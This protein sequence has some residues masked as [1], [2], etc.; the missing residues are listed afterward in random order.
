MP[1]N[2][3]G[4]R[5]NARSQTG[6]FLWAELRQSSGAERRK[7]VAH[8]VS[9]GFPSP[10]V[11]QPWRGGRILG[12][13]CECRAPLSPL[14][15]SARLNARPTAYAVGYSLPVLRTFEEDANTHTRPAPIR[16]IFIG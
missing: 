10:W 8:S 3:K 2:L 16:N 15:G 11:P 12:T 14:R 5:T 1:R 13:A 7:K 9:C 4:F 6:Y